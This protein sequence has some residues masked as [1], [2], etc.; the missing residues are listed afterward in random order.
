M[1]QSQGVALS[2][3]WCGLLTKQAKGFVAGGSMT[4]PGKEQGSPDGL[5]GVRR[6]KAEGCKEES[7]A[8]L[9]PTSVTH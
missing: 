6:R 5:H 2:I 7:A 8:S 3:A 1:M 9:P 4:P